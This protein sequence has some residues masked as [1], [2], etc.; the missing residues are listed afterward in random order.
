MKKIA[1][2]CTVIALCAGH[3]L[4]ADNDKDE[5]KKVPP[6][7]QKKGGVPPGQAKKKGQSEEATPAATPA[8]ANTPAPAST[9][10][11]PNTPA[12]PANTTAPAPATTPAATA[13]VIPATAKPPTTAPKAPS[14]ADQR[15]A[16]ETHAH[17]INQT[18]KSS[19]AAHNVALQH[20]SKETGVSLEHLKEQD[21]SFPAAS[22]TGLLLGNLIAKK[23][24][25][26]F[27]DVMKAHQS[28]KHWDEIAK[29]HNVDFGLLVQKSSALA[30]ALRAK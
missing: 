27:G 5:G 14:L 3:A 11:Q 8:P 2:L 21:K 18:T 9:P 17:A 25:V 24:G 23:S 10:A 28:G 15:A 20:I 30:Q 6:G 13:P 29:A 22:D 26:K 4:S 19:P 12:A 1:T 7:L 16:L